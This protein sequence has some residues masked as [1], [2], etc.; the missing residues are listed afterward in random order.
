[1]LVLQY[2]PTTLNSMH[3]RLPTPLAPAVPG[4]LLMILTTPCTPGG[5]RLHPLTGIAVP[6]IDPSVTSMTRMTSASYVIS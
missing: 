3:D 6:P 4:T 5:S 1:M 2:T